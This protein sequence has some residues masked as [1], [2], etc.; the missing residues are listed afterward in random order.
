M[1]YAKVKKV[2]IYI[3]CLF[4]LVIFKTSGQQFKI[5]P[6]RTYLYKSEIVNFSWGKNLFNDY[7]V[8]ITVND[9]EKI[10]LDTNIHETFFNFKVPVNIDSISISFG[11]N[12]F[13]EIRKFHIIHDSLIEYS[14]SWNLLNHNFS[15]IPRDGAG[16]L[17]FLNKIWIFGG[18]N[19]LLDSNVTNSQVYNSS[20]G[21]KWNFIS[22]APWEKRHTSGWLVHR[23]SIYLIGGDNITGKY[24]MDVWNSG[25]GVKWNKLVDSL[26]FSKR[27]LFNYASLDGKIWVI[28]GEQIPWNSSFSPTQDTLYS[29]VWSSV[30]GRIWVKELDSLPFIPRAMSIGNINFKNCLWMIGGGTYQNRIYKNKPLPRSYYN[31]VW[32]STNGKDW[33]EVEISTPWLKRHFQNVV[34]FDDKIWL[35]NGYDLNGENKRDVW[36]TSNGKNWIELKYSPWIP[37]HASTVVSSGE[38]LYMFFGPLDRNDFYRLDKNLLKVHLNTTINNFTLLPSDKFE[39]LTDYDLYYNYFWYLNNILINKSNKISLLESGI[40]YLNV[41]N[42]SSS[43]FS[44]TIKCTVFNPIIIGSNNYTYLNGDTMKLS[45]K[46]YTSFNYNWRKIGYD[47]ILA[48]GIN[49][50]STISGEYYVNVNSIYSTMCSDTIRAIFYSPIIDALIRKDIISNKNEVILK[51]LFNSK[52]KYSWYKDGH[53]IDNYNSNE[54][55]VNEFGLYYATI[56]SEQGTILESNR[57]FINEQYLVDNFD[58]VVSFRNNNLSLTFD[59]KYIGNGTVE[60]FDINGKRL[61]HFNFIKSEK[62]FMQTFQTILLINQIYIVKIIFN[63]NSK[64][65]KIFQSN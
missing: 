64:T 65:I 32:K 45:I 58:Y 9:L 60:I 34:E 51:L 42:S 36:Y 31:E 30:D 8:N 61:N 21:I 20:D 54:I 57:I 25:D 19:S 27:V 33:I 53:K 13:K 5:S 24:Q 23:D 44:D 4:F 29:D 1:L 11:N 3:F 40:Y 18:W 10:L 50:S 46:D 26:P 7:P 55:K 56:E 14:Y 39:V 43:I 12:Y 38:H 28:C 35:I 41:S 22:N 47:S 48:N 63:G 49:Y 37:R 52:W 2:A 62:I 15:G 17:Y 59:T 16:G 6:N